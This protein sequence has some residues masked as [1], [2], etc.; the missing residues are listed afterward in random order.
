VPP[1]SQPRSVGTPPSFVS[2]T[3]GTDTEQGVATP[4]SVSF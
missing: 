3:S 2:D 1:T 4:D